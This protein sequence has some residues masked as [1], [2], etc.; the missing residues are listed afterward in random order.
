MCNAPLLG[1]L[2][3][4]ELGHAVWHACMHAVHPILKI[5]VNDD[6]AVSVQKLVDEGKVKYLGLSEVSAEDLRKAHAIH[7]ISAVQ[8]VCLPAHAP[9][10]ASTVL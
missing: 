10:N 7:P 6:V 1:M 5:S 8:L 4:H 3:E 2:Q 9:L